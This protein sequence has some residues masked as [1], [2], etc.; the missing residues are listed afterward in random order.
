MRREKTENSEKG[1]AIIRRGSTTLVGRSK[2]ASKV[3]R[4]C[5]VNRQETLVP[6]APNTLGN[7]FAV[8]GSD[9]S[10]KRS[11]ISRLRDR[12][13]QWPR[14]RAQHRRLT[15]LGRGSR[16]LRLL[17]PID[18]S[19]TPQYLCIYATYST[20]GP[21]GAQATLVDETRVSSEKNALS[22]GK[23]NVHG[24]PWTTKMSVCTFSEWWRPSREGQ[25]S[26]PISNDRTYFLRTPANGCVQR[27]ERADDSPIRLVLAF[28]SFMNLNAETNRNKESLSAYRTAFAVERNRF[29]KENEKVRK[30]GVK[31][32]HSLIMILDNTIL[33]IE[34]TGY[35][36]THYAITSS[37]YVGAGN[38]RCNYFSAHSCR[39]NKNLWKDKSKNSLKVYVRPVW[40]GLNRVNFFQGTLMVIIMI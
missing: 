31:F 33:Y 6:F 29:L 8:S 18:F 9:G 16:S 34:Q 7:K 39:C 27:N 26:R 30:K 15:W 23:R 38:N 35:A 5:A 14:R 10:M 20:L 36:L 12:E 11:I 4:C 19:R 3:I 32:A 24:R 25:A 40:L 1:S 13:K 17:V 37:H 2:R 21:F 22:R 28:S